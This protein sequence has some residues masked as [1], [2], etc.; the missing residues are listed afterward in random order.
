MKNRNRPKFDTFTR[1]RAISKIKTWTGTMHKAVNACRVYDMYG[2]YL[3]GNEV[4]QGW[5]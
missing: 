5:A 1:K 2:I 3:G 4:N